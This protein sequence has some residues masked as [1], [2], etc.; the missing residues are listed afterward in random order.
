MSQYTLE[1]IAKDSSM[2]PLSS[3][4]TLIIHV[5]DV[6]DNPPAFEQESYAR[7]MLMPVSVGEKNIFTEISWHLSSQSVFYAF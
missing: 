5:D 7:N 1:I 6:N 3:M 4:T 2:L